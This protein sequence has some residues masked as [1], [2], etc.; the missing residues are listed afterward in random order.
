MSR[1]G[2]LRALWNHKMFSLQ[3][4]L[5][6][7]LCQTALEKFCLSLWLFGRFF[8]TTRMCVNFILENLFHM[9]LL[10]FFSHFFCR[11]TLAYG[12]WYGLFTFVCRCNVST[13]YFHGNRSF[14]RL[15]LRLRNHKL[16][17]NV[18]E[19][20]ISISGKIPPFYCSTVTVLWTDTGYIVLIYI[21]VFAYSF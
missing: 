5:E 6:M 8:N 10:A 21:I 12:R 17:W 2:N 9:A 19:K 1:C 13:P 20:F 14:L 4:V 11:V 15:S 16:Q 18:N 7:C 3:F